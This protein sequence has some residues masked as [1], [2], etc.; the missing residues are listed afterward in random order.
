MPKMPEK[1]AEKNRARAKAW[2]EMNRSRKR[3]NNSAW[4][5]R[6]PEQARACVQ[7]WRDRN[8][9]KSAASVAA[10]AHRRRGA[11]GQLT[12]VDVTALRASASSCAYCGASGRLHV[13]HC[14]PLARGGHN[15]PSNVVLACA[16]C[17]WSKGTKTVLEFFG[18]WPEKA[19]A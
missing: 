11:P 12:R 1:T 6:H 16:A 13:E 15:D 5:A 8:P 14:T 10:T 4:R 18:L 19:A 7:A 17:N 2:T 9:E 3:S